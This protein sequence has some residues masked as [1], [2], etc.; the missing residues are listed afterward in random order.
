[1]IKLSQIN[2]E[3]N[4]EQSRQAHVE[5]KKLKK[6]SRCFHLSQLMIFGIGS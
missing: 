4:K 3:T 5:S 2:N 1:M 6:V